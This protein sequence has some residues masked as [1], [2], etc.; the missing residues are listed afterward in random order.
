MCADYAYDISLCQN[1]QW[2][3]VNNVYK[4][5]YTLIY[6]PESF[7]ILVKSLY[8]N[9]QWRHT[10][11]VIWTSTHC[12]NGM[13]NIIQNKHNKLPNSMTFLAWSALLRNSFII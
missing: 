10:M 3:I 11:F 13:I 2:Q 1:G 8:D 4:I 9:S 5:G 12:Q 6:F 7:N